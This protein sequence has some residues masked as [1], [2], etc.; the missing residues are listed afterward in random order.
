[1]VLRV[2]SPATATVQTRPRPARLQGIRLPA[3]FSPNSEAGM[4]G[5]GDP[6]VPSGHWP[7]G[8]GRSFVLPHTF[9]KVRAPS[10]FRAASRRSAQA[11]GLCY[12]PRLPPLLRNSG[13][14]GM[15]GA[16][17]RPLSGQAWRRTRRGRCEGRPAAPL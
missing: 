13:F 17:G 4:G 15:T 9:G 6:P 2:A 10:P 7:D 8:T 5:T 12:S 1:M 16:V 11:S 14:N 3:G